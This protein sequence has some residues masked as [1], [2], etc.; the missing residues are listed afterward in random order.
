[1][2]SSGKT[3]TSKDDGAV[4]IEII[5]GKTARPYKAKQIIFSQGDPGDAIFYIQKGR[6]KLAVVSERGKEAIVGILETNA[7]FGEQCLAREPIRIM[8]AT[9]AED[10]SLIRIEKGSM[11]RV[12]RFNPEISERFV[13]YL[14]FR[15]KRMHEDLVDHLFNH[16]EKRLARLLLL[17]SHYGKSGKTEPI[18][19]KINQETLAEMVG[20]TR[21]RISFFMKKFKKLGFIDYNHNDGLHVHSSLLNMVL[22]D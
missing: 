21:G 13:S 6:V 15:N 11:L 18:I 12:M 16:S 19:P 20:T 2:A 4:V 10:C 22:H 7:F 9:A 3:T 5:N 8:T 1:M 17:L 14:L